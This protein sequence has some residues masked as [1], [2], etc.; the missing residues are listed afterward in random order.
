MSHQQIR[1]ARAKRLAMNTVSNT[2]FSYK[3]DGNDDDDV[4]DDS[5]SIHPI[6]ALRWVATRLNSRYRIDR[7]TGG[8]L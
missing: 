3:G 6:L 7:L 2:L 4:D 1:Y 5:P 8:L